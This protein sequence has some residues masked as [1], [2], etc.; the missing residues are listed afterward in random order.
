[1]LPDSAEFALWYVYRGG[2][3][4]ELHVVYILTQ[5]H[6]PVTEYSVS[7]INSR[8]GKGEVIPVRVTKVSVGGGAEV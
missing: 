7:C 6:D 5:F 1:M 8:G 4:A 3:K 2:E